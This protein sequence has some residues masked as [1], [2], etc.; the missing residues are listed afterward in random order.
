[1][2]RKFLKRNNNPYFVQIL[3]DK[4]IF[5]KTYSEFLGRKVIRS[6]QYLSVS[7]LEYVFDGADKLVY[8]PKDGSGG[9]GIQIIRKSE[10]PDLNVLAEKL[11]SMPEAVIEQWINQHEE[12]SKAYPYAVNCLRIAT[13]YRDNKC[14]LLGGIFT[15]GCQ[16]AEIA[17]ALQHSIF[18]LINM[19]TGEV[20]TDLCDYSDNYYKEHPDTGFVSKGFIIPYWKEIVQLVEKASAVVPQIGYVGWDVAISETGPVLI[21]GN[22]L[23]AGYIGYQHYLLRED[24]KGSYDIWGKFIN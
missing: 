16:K 11:R 21:E 18:G 10:Y 19:E 2:F 13:L 5:S 6:N 23:S 22:S 9:M 3:N 24:R 17:N 12:M 7:D 20:F 14:T 15:L 1:M 8:K 4:Y